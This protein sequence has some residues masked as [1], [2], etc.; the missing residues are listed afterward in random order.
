MKVRILFVRFLLILLIMPIG[1]SSASTYFFSPDSVTATNSA[2]G[3]GA[4]SDPSKTPCAVGNLIDQSGLDVSQVTLSNIETV[5]H[6]DQNS[7]DLWRGSGLG[8]LTFEFTDPTD[9][10]FVGMWQ[11]LIIEQPNN[12]GSQEVG[13]FSLSFFNNAGDLIGDVYTE[14][15]DP[16][17]GPITLNG[18]LFDVGCRPGVS[19]IK[20]HIDTIAEPTGGYVH[21]GEFMVAN[22]VPIPSALALFFSGFL[23]L[24]GVKSWQRKHV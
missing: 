23:A 18:H 21:F 14:K 16:V 9:I 7:T 11:G 15:V 6:S 13:E 19:S 5:M 17:S 20:M 12:I 24:L 3:C 8:T 1:T 2:P 10:G 4:G 22:P